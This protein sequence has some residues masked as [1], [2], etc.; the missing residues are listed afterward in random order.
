M[1]WWHLA[2]AALDIFLVVSLGPWIVLQILEAAMHGSE[3]FLDEER[4]R[5]IELEK[6]AL[7][8][9]AVWPR[10]VR[11]G[12]YQ[13]HDEQALDSLS[14]LLDAVGGARTRLESATP[15]GPMYTTLLDALV[16]KS[17][18]RLA[19]T[20]RAWLGRRAF[21]RHLRRGADAQAELEEQARAVSSIPERVRGSLRELRAEQRRL[22]AILEAEQAQGTRG[23]G[24]TA[25][26]L[27]GVE[28]AVQDALEELATATPTD[29]TRVIEG[30]DT[31]LVQMGPTLDGLDALVT[32]ASA[33]RTEA[34]NAVRKAQSAIQ[35][36]E[37]RWR[38]L[39]QRGAKE[40]EIA[41]DLASLQADVS[42]LPQVLPGRTVDGYRQVAQ[43]AASLDERFRR[44]DESM[45]QLDEL[46][47][48]ARNAVKGDFQALAQAQ[49]LCE[50]LVADTPLLNPDESLRLV[51]Q[52]SDAFAEA[53]RQFAAGTTLGF[54]GSISLANG[55]HRLLS[56]A[57][58]RAEALPEEADRVAELLGTLDD[59]D[60]AACRNRAEAARRQLEGYTAHW[61]ADWASVADNSLSEV[62][63]AEEA[64]GRVATDVRTVQVFRQ[65]ELT[66][67]LALLAQ[68]QRSK[69]SAVELTV[70]LER[71]ARRVAELREDLEAGVARLDSDIWPA[72]LE[73][74]E[75]MLPELRQRVRAARD[76]FGAQVASLGDPAAVDYDDVTAK[77]L[78]SA[79]RVVEEIGS[80]HELDREHYRHAAHDAQRRLDRAWAR[81]QRLTPDEPPGP[82]E[83]IETLA[84]DLDEWRME[85]EEKRD[86]PLALSSLTAR[87]AQLLE[88]RIAAATQEIAEGRKSF[89]G[90]EK[91]YRRRA[92]RVHGLRSAVREQR[93]E[94]PWRHLHWGTDDADRLWE[95]ATL[96][97]RSAYSAPKL[98]QACDQLQKALSAA[99]EAEQAYMRVED[100]M[101]SSLGRLSQE[102]D[103]VVSGVRRARRRAA[104]LQQAAADGDDE[105]SEEA[106]LLVQAI[107]GVE[108]TLDLA[109]ASTTFEDALR[110]IRDASNTLSRAG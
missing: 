103:R 21:R 107:E 10:E 50:R 9:E 42:R 89:E 72:L 36:S 31:M 85:V 37:E 1:E 78:P 52:A 84:D 97:E 66:D 92:Q 61:N 110:H 51:E 108:R 48:R 25:K 30:V 81:L 22:A 8:H 11:S 2:V 68:A 39:D 93:R 102:R 63:T 16:L 105:S 67:A 99:E 88:Q 23:L 13:K 98:L 3:P 14:R 62:A 65:T 75:E 64:L 74:S 57:L 26:R 41:Q 95:G 38:G 19:T 6:A 35:L 33:T 4:D 77:W 46:M 69:E 45:A 100:Q 83:D 5:L 59:Q 90:L 44:L 86:S 76:E 56:R 27:R 106:A 104:Q 28:W 60:L 24:E 109:Y 7:Q 79:R 12:R 32:G 80:T 47:Q 94:S 40:P 29:M 87:L 55:A 91:Q 43:R 96:C 54:Q 82:E 58:E 71:E 53:E 34:G 20:F 18:G 49:E 15:Y 70:D 101:K 73:R 17:W